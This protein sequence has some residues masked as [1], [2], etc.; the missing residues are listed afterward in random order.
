MHKQ[1]L[2]L[3]IILSINLDSLFAG[4]DTGINTSRAGVFYKND[5]GVSRVVLLDQ[6]MSNLHYSGFGG[7][8]NF[9]RFSIT[10]RRI[11]EWS[12]ARFQYN[13]A[14]PGHQNTRVENPGAGIRYMHLRNF[15]AQQNQ[16]IYA[17]GQI[18]VF[19]NAR[20][21]PRLGNSFLHAD[22]I[23]EIRPQADLSLNRR[24]LWREWNID[25]S[26]AASIA[27]YTLRVPEYG[28]SFEISDDGG[29]KVQGYE[30]KLLT[31]F[32]YG[33]V[34]TG[35]FIREFFRGESNPNWFRV[36]YVWDYY[37]M[38]GD[39]NLN[40]NN[41]LHQIVLELYFRVR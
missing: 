15:L 21:A 20:M 2:L 11:T 34:T 32:N 10:Q 30:N 16:N 38:K 24:F 37:T 28:V 33:H 26:M 29:V 31:P 1:F 27:G 12:F 7:I 13:N 14:R 3:V 23:A 6:R 39:H 4:A 25:M 36:G 40:M 17:G 35:V 5:I 8:L 18:N 9:G 19:G 41:A 22:L